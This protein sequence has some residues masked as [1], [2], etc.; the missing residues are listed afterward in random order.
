M[1]P[2]TLYELQ[3]NCIGRFDLRG[4]CKSTTIALCRVL[5]ANGGHVIGLPGKG[6]AALLKAGRLKAFFVSG[7]GVQ[8][9]QPYAYLP[10]WTKPIDRR[11]VPGAV[12]K[13]AVLSVADVADTGEFCA[14]PHLASA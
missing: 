11:Y 6:E 5:Q 13:T 12:A 3:V 4:L 1:R 10:L 9:I 14:E 7:K 8:L 2:E